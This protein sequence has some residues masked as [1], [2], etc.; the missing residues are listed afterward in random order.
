MLQEFRMDGEKEQKGV[1]VYMGFHSWS[2]GPAPLA[3]RHDGNH[4]CSQV[5][6]L[7]MFEPF[8]A[9]RELREEHHPLGLYLIGWC[10]AQTIHSVNLKITEE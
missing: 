9:K 8:L 2:Y 1:V 6:L 7:L 10:T 5:L 4:S 3:P